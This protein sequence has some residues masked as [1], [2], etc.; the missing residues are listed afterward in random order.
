M[1][2]GFYPWLDCQLVIVSMVIG[3]DGFGDAFGHEPCVACGDIDPIDEW[4]KWH[5]GGAEA[6]AFGS[7][8]VIQVGSQ[9]Y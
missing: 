9:R 4:V 5:L 6:L 1:F 2:V 8:S 3:L 7:G